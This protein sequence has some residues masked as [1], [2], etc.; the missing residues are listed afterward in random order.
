VHQLISQAGMR[1]INGSTAPP[2]TIRVPPP[3]ARGR[4]GHRQEARPLPWGVGNAGGD[5]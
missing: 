3:A 1:L 2:A 4:R 5:L